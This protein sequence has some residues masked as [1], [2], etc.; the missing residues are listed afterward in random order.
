V[1]TSTDLT[2]NLKNT[3]AYRAT[4]TLDIPPGP[5]SFQ[6]LAQLDPGATAPLK[7]TY[8]PGARGVGDLKLVIDLQ[9]DTDVTGVQHHQHFEISLTGKAIAPSIFLA[10]GPQQFV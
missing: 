7:I 1:G 5:F 9:S 8:Q 6:P 2:L 10:A 3:G 4:L